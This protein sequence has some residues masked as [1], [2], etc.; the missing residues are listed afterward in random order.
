MGAQRH[1]HPK[2]NESGW[3]GVAHPHQREGLAQDQPPQSYPPVALRKPPV[4]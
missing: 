2:W 4:W 3:A 1:L